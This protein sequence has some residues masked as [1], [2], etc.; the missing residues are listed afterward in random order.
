MTNVDFRADMI[1]QELV[2]NADKKI[3]QVQLTEKTQVLSSQSQRP[4]YLQRLQS[5]RKYDE[6]APD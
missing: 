1:R 4:I 2:C 6:A 5:L 3:H